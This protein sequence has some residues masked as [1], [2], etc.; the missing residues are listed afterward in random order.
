MVTN[1]QRAFIEHYLATQAVVELHLRW[2]THAKVEWSE[3][4]LTETE[5]PHDRAALRVRRPGGGWPRAK[6]VSKLR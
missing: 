2:A 6:G 4:S 1:R 5:P 3:V